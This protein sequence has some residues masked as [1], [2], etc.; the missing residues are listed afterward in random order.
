MAKIAVIVGEG[1][2]DS[3][4]TKPVEAFQNAGH[5][6]TYV[7]LKKGSVVKGKKEGTPIEIE[8][9]VKGALAEEFDA[10]LIPGGYSPDKLRAHEEPVSF[11]R[12][13]MKSGKPVFSICHGP[14]LLITADTL[15]GRTCT[16][17]QSITQDIKNAGATFVDQEVVV[18][19]NLITSRQP[20]DIPAFCKACLS[21]L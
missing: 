16:G 1:F 17:Y 19:D 13:F 11:A 14:Q 12:E 21:K 9:E 3:E 20:S 2:E 7:G 4:L 8:L 15:R 5:Q 18:D 6:T 10:L